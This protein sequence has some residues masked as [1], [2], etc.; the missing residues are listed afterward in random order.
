MDI[1]GFE[2]AG[3]LVN[4]GVIGLAVLFAV[5]PEQKKSGWGNIGTRNV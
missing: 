2:V 1:F 4:A 5:V 3:I